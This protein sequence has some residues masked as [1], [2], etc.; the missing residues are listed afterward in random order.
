MGILWAD[1]AEGAADNAGILVLI[2][3]CMTFST[4]FCRPGSLRGSV[5]F[6]SEAGLSVA[7]LSF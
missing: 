7:D 6:R 2:M 1:C 3:S 4:P 5:I